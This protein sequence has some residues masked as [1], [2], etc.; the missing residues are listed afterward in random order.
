MA[1]EKINQKEVEVEVDGE[2]VKVVVKKPN[3]KI[4][5]DA[6]RRGALVWT[7][8]VRDGV[9]TKK[10]LK[11]FMKERGIWD[12]E[13]DADEAKKVAE[14]A[15][16]EKK[17]YLGSKGGR[18]KASEGKSIAIEMRV[19]RNEL[20]ELLAERIQLEANTAEA[21]SE[22]AKFDF[23]VASCTYYSTGDKVFE[24]LDDYGNRAEDGIA[25]AAAQNLAELLYSVDKDFEEKL[26]ENRFLKDFK[27]VNE[28]LSLVNKDGHTVDTKGRL[29][30]KDGHYLDDEGNRVDT[31]GNLLDED[32]NYIPTIK[33]VDDNGRVIRKTQPKKEEK[34]E[35]ATSTSEDETGS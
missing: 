25:F 6:Q 12:D 16:L 34:E 19:K 13:K 26:P 22:N 4:L 15:N 28:D 33:Y 18:L 9:M 30:N 14:I 27:F 29:I 31:D 24:D 17:L 35:V 7:E 32:G 20:R 10:E 21:L 11:K 2:K 5:N 1:K 3:T 8:C 23:L